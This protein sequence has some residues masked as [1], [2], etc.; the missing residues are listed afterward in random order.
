MCNNKKCN[1]E[2]QL[3]CEQTINL[4]VSNFEEDD[5][6]GF[7]KAIEY[8]LIFH[9]N[10]DRICPNCKSRTWQTISEIGD[11]PLLAVNVEN[12]SLSGRITID[13]LP[14]LIEIYNKQ[15]KLRRF[16]KYSGPIS[17]KAVSLGHCIGYFMELKH[18]GLSM[19]IF[20]KI[21]YFQKK[22][23]NPW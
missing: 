7:N 21:Y 1:F 22:F 19:M 2:K 9:D 13:S 23:L 11:G 14:R 18:V 6:N 3:L 10:K 17:K 4:H 16:I 15:Y 12:F 5:S 8:T 20:L